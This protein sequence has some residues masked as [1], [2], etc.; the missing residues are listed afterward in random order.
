M[1]ACRH[2]LNVAW[3]L[4]GSAAFG[5]DLS[6]IERTLA[7]EPAYR[8]KPRYCLLVFGPEAKTRI[9]LVQDGDTL[10][11]DRNGNGDLTEPGKKVSPDNREE[12]A[13]DGVFTFKIG[14]IHD[15][16]RVHKEVSL[17]VVKLDYAIETD[18]AIKKFLAKSPRGRGYSLMAE[19]EMP[20]W[21][22]ARPGGRI[23][24]RTWYTDVNSV[25]QFADR[26]QDA[27]IVH[28]GGP[29]QI[30]LCG[31]HRLTIGRESDV[32]LCVGTPGVG[33][34]TMTYIDYDCV[35]PERVYPT[36]EITYPARAA[37]ETAR[38]VHYTLKRRC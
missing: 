31:G 3:L 20:R 37:N 10:Y 12:G 21:K 18:D 26:P 6:R 16:Q 7:R 9:W 11:V 13:D 25:F 30:A 23:Q 4:S 34:A 29:W 33:P 5:A 35:I 19:V 24:Q 22:G 14:E 27:P 8:L 1:I 17:S 32:V 28:F 15:G 2:F 38:T 36:L